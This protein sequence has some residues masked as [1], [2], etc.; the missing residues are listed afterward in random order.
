MP[1][2]IALARAFKALSHPRRARLYRLLAEDPEIGRSFSA[3]QTAT[4][5]GEA[6]LVHHLREMERC[7]LLIRRRLGN[8]VAHILT[9]GPLTRALADAARL[10]RVAKG[11]VPLRVA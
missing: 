10:A 3:I 2:D 5:I 1:D 6:P 11:P 8:S 9:P 4:G 7:G